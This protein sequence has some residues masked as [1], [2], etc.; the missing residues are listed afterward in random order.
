MHQ[1]VAWH[2]ELTVNPGRME[3]FLR[4][5]DE[6]VEVA[7]T[8]HGVLAYERFESADGRVHVYERYATAVDAA[9][10]LQMFFERFGQ[11]F[12]ALVQREQFTVFGHVTPELRE[13][14][15]PLQVRY[16]QPLTGFANFPSA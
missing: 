14:L 9:A 2:V 8:E 3:E 12:G 16:A 1:Q 5:T 4:L 11:Q 13:L 15:D 10:H 6:M 7:R